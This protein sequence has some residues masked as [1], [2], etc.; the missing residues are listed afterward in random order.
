MSPRSSC[1]QSDDMI[2]FK[3]DGAILRD[4]ECV[5][6]YDEETKVRSMGL[7]SRHRPS[8]VIVVCFHRR[9]RW[10]SLTPASRFCT[11]TRTPPRARQPPPVSTC[12]GLLCC[13]GQG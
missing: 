6:I 8:S 11:T 5:L 3:G 9:S 12:L 7:C 1:I 4:I 13:H 2:R 10:R